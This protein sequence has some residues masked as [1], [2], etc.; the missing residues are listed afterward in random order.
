MRGYRNG[1]YSFVIDSSFQPFT[2]QEMLQPFVAYKDAYEKT[3]E[4]YYDLSDKADKFKYLSKTLPEGSEARQI[5]EGYAKDL[6]QQAESL[7]KH[8]LS[9]NNRRALTD[10]KRRY[11][12]E[13]GQLEA[14]KT[15]LDKE[16]DRRTALFGKDPSMIYA[17]DNLNIDQFLG[18]TTPNLYAVSGEDL[19]KEGALYA[20]QASSRIY[21]D[22]RVK[23]INKYF[24]DIIQTQGYSP[25]LIA[26]WRQRLESIPV[27]NQ[28][29]DDIMHAR[30]VDGNLTGVN[31]ERARQSIINGIMEGAA[32]QE[33]H[34][35]YQN[36]GVLTAAQVA[37]NARQKD[38]DTRAREQMELSALQNG[39]VR[40][41]GQWVFK[42]EIYKQRAKALGMESYNPDDW[43]I[44]PDGKLRKKTK[45]KDKNTTNKGGSKN[46]TD[47]K[48]GIDSDGNEYNAGGQ[49]YKYGKKISYEEALKKYPAVSNWDPNEY[50]FY[51]SGT[52]IH[53]RP[54]KSKGVSSGN[55][56]TSAN[57]NIDQ[58]V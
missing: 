3:E 28:A 2:F 6:T 34:T 51:D 49:N 27:F 57:E 38:A 5:Y 46:V 9:M 12:G 54:S 25:E 37:A 26:A 53:P 33:K 1:N 41:G 7:A 16:R 13:I 47:P 20:Q 50:D 58:Q 56:N 29:V 14:A 4:A 36:P 43:E 35:P 30:G 22:S 10:L 24:Q 42:P 31:Y 48:V 17:E 18:D 11:K 52:R 8:G 23:D 45:D 55:S 19:R 44:G 32:Y 21:G 15:A 39:Y 40:E